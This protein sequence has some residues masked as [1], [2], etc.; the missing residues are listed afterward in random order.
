[1]K[2]SHRRL[3]TLLF[4]AGDG[5]DGGLARAALGGRWYWTKLCVIY[6]CLF[7]FSATFER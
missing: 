4:F 5:E 3:I 7:P 1:M 2:L 6:L